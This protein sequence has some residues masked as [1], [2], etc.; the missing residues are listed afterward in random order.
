MIELDDSLNLKIREMSANEPGTPT[1]M[2]ERSFAYEE[3]FSN[4]VIELR[5]IAAL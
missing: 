1:K 4:S 3:D 2:T 5:D